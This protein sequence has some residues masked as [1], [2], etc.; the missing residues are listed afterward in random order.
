MG[1]FINIFSEQEDLSMYVTSA[2]LRQT[3]NGCPTFILLLDGG[4]EVN[5]VFLSSGKL[6]Y[7]LTEPDIIC[8]PDG[9]FKGLIM[10]M[11]LEFIRG[12]IDGFDAPK[13]F[14]I[15]RLGEMDLAMTK[16]YFDALMDERPGKDLDASTVSL[17]KAILVR[18]DEI[19][20]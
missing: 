13:G 20:G 11:S 10:N 12:V 9:N 17:V 2:P 5:G 19:L 1:R 15:R 8:T 3:C 4:L 16:L 6:A 14:R 18:F 7:N